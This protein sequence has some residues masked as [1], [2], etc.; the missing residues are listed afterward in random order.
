MTAMGR[1][2]YEQKSPIEALRAYLRAN[3]SLYDR[4]KNNALKRFILKNLSPIRD[5]MVLEVGA[6]GGIWTRFWLDNGARVTSIDIHSPI[7]LGNKMWNPEA[8]FLVADGTTVKFTAKFD[9][10]SAKDVIEHIIDDE[11]FLANMSGHLEDGGHLFIN[12]Q[13]F[14]SINYL[15][16]GGYNFLIRRNRDWCGWDPT[17]VRFY[18]FRQLSAKLRRAGLKPVKWF[19]TY[20]FPYR[21]LSALILKRVI[22][23]PY[24][25]LV[26]LLNLN[27]K[28][29][30]NLFGWNIGV[31]AKKQ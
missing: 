10:I 28:F 14:L 17:H 30:F 16:E 1:D 25:Q 6:G 8:D 3:E 19:G 13:N 24:L 27:D 22:E 4:L 2:F 7:L 18:N 5:K 31:I 29:P 21:F 23:R 12:T 26:E 9:I 15:V 20:H 11:M